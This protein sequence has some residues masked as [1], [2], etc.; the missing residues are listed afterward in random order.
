MTKLLI[1][2]TLA[3]SAH[4]ASAHEGH[5][6]EGAQAMNGGFVK[7]GREI[8]MEIVQEGATIKLFPLGHDGKPIAAKDVELKATAKAGSRGKASKPEEIKFKPEGNS[9]VATPQIKARNYKLEVKAKHKNH[10][11][12][13]FEFPVEV[14]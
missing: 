12:D 1:C 13:T 4:A 2:L 3:F 14:Q 10:P 7:N 11:A 6:N 9:F 8:S 5:G